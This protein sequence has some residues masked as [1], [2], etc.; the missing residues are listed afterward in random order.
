MAHVAVARTK[1]K[2]ARAQHCEKHNLIMLIRLGYFF[3]RH[4]FS[5]SGLELALL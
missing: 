4:K 3:H 2:V 5:V 1:K